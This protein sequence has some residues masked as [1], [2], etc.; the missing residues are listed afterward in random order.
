MR[1]EQPA[2]F[3]E[4]LCQ[5][6]L[7]AFQR[8]HSNGRRRALAKSTP[9]LILGF[10]ARTVQSSLN[11]DHHPSSNL[12][13]QQRWRHRNCFT[14]ADYFGR[15]R[16][17]PGDIEIT[18][19]TCPGFKPGWARTHHTVDPGERHAAQNERRDRRRKI[20]SPSQTASGNYP[21]VLGCG[22]NVGKRVTANHID[23]PRPPRLLERF[24]WVREFRPSQHLRGAQAFQ[25]RNSASSDLLLMA[26]TR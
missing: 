9:R 13:R 26:A 8:Q 20:H 22:A 18:S 21:A 6:G 15:N 4:P 17:E 24:S 25:K 10:L 23:R 3:W 16:V 19:Q 7:L 1:R 2:R 12:T 14:Q 11:V 5:Q